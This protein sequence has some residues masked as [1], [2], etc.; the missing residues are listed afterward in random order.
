M[1]DSATSIRKEIKEDMKELKDTMTAGFQDL[2]NK[3]DKEREYNSK[4]YVRQD[5]HTATEDARKSFEKKA[6]AFLGIV[7]PLVTSVIIN[8]IK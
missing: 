3:I 2:S 6:L 4:T 8:I 5:V 7:I 1:S